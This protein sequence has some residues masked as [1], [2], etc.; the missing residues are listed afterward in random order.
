MSNK[1]VRNLESKYLLKQ[2][3]KDVQEI[4]DFLKDKSKF[5]IT[6]NPDGTVPTITT[7]G[8]TRIIGEYQ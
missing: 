2:I 5:V 8:Y 7:D 4:T 1:D 6:L 3:E